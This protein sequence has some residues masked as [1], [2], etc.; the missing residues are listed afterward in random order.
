MSLFA[1]HRAL[2][3]GL[4]LLLGQAG[5]AQA[6]ATRSAAPG[7]GF[8]DPKGVPP[9]PPVSDIRPTR[10]SD[11]VDTLA[12]VR[13]RGTLRVGVVPVA[14]MVMR[15]HRGEWVGYSIDLSRRLAQDMGVAVEFVPSTWVDVMPDLLQRRFDL[16]ATGLWVSIPRAL[17]V[18]FTE[19]TALEGVHL[20]A[21]RVKAAARTSRA[22]FDR[23][24][25]TLAVVAGTPQAALARR[26]FPQATLLSLPEGEVD[27]VLD[28]RADAAL[29]PTIAPQAVLAAAPGRL[30]MPLELPLSA[31]PAAIA[32]RK[33]DADFLAFLNT[34]LTVVRGEGWLD[35][36]ATHW[37]H[38]LPPR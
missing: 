6:Q 11:F 17:V 32:I 28:G 9:R 37:A 38:G 24:E 2:A 27:A 33:G 15:D 19:P 23:P 25:V 1:I 22:D 31:T 29:L 21:S 10:R 36:R 8:A 14:P 26:V 18:N 35:E 34:W 3:L 12:T 7:A 5:V 20:V 4:L 30:F 16:V 13:R